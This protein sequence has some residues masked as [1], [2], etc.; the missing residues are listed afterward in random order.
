MGGPL[1]KTERETIALQLKPALSI[2][3]KITN[4]N[5]TRKNLK[6]LDR[7]NAEV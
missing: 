1:K 5:T 6:R 2:G 3:E 4:R 7:F